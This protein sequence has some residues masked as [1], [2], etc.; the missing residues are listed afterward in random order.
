MFVLLALNHPL[1][2]QRIHAIHSTIKRDGMLKRI[3]E[4]RLRATFRL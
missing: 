1:A 3:A 2:P 4:V